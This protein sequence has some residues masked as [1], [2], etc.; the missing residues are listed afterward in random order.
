MWKIPTVPIDFP[1]SVLMYIDI[2]SQFW[3]TKNESW[4]PHHTHI[5]STHGYIFKIACTGIEFH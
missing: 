4:S 3:I 5:V 1:K 2:I